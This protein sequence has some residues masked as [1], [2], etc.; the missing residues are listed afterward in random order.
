M[1]QIDVTPASVVV[2]QRRRRQKISR[3][4]ERTISNTVEPEILGRIGGV[5][6]VKTPAKI[7]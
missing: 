1:G 5:S 2:R 7:Q 4:L 3:L 6:K